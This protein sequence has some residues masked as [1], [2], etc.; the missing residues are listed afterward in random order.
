MLRYCLIYRFILIPTLVFNYYEWNTIYKKN[1]IRSSLLLNTLNHKLLNYVKSIVLRLFSIY[2]AH[3]VSLTISLNVFIKA[4]TQSKQI[5]Y[6]LIGL[7]QT[8]ICHIL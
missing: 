2:V 4:F 8:Y 6:L 5:I 3:G 1:N 7:H